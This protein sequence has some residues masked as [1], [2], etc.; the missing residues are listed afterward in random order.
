MIVAEHETALLRYATRLVNDP[1]TA[2][3]VVQKTFIKLFEKWRDKGYPEMKNIRAWLYR[4]THNG[5][6]DHIRHESRL[7]T[8]HERHTEEA[9][10]ADGHHC[11]TPVLK[12]R[13]EEVLF[14]LKQLDESEQQVVLLRMEQG[15][16]YQEIAHVTGRSVGNVGCV[17]HHAVK[18]LAT[19]VQPEVTS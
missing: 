14:H 11:P 3:D 19:R 2:Q 9:A 7:N 18:K 12:D 17:L 1:H 10:C 8:L 15:L 5:A 13:K 16:S 6:I 4:V